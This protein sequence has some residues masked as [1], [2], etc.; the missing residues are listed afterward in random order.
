MKVYFVTFGRNMWSGQR[1]GSKKRT[2]WG[3]DG[4]LP[5]RYCGVKAREYISVEAGRVLE[6]YGLTFV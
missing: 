5:T 3:V 2:Q 1:D 6:T 4:G